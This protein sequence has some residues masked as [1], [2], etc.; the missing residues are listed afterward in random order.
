MKF[1]ITLGAF[2]VAALAIWLCVD[3]LEQSRD[4]SLPTTFTAVKDLADH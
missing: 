2:S 1:V 3:A 4:I